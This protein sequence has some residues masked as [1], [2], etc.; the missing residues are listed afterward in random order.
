MRLFFAVIFTS[1]F[2]LT[3]KAQMAEPVKWTFNAEKITNTEFKLT[4][5]A[6]IQD[7]WYVYSQDLPAK[8]PI[9]TQIKF[10]QN[11]NFV[12]EGKP[13]ELGERKE[14]FDQNFNMTVIKLIGKTEYVQRVKIVNGTPSVKGKLTY[15][16]C[17]GELC[18]P[19]KKIDFNIVLNN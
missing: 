13:Q 3:V 4:L 8:G 5:T 18:M 1:L 12:L 7:G 6:T 16:T 15:M 9:P 11:P 10:E 19:P 2:S 14:I 17:N